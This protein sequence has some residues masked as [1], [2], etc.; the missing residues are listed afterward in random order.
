MTQ[1]NRRKLKAVGKIAVGAVR[2]ASGVATAFG[3]GLLGSF[4][5]TNISP[6]VRQQIGKLS[7]QGGKKM[8]DEGCAEL[9][10]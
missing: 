9:R 10:G 4:L 2:M 6:I 8:F 1:E 3:V 7:I 5:R